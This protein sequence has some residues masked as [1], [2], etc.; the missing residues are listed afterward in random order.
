L[1]QHCVLS[2]KEEKLVAS[3]YTLISSEALHPLKAEREYARLFRNFVIEYA[4]LF[5]KKVEDVGIK[6]TITTE[7]SA[8]SEVRTASRPSPPNP[9]AAPNLRLP[10]LSG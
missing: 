5:A 2:E 6:P 10:S 1:Q 7:P 3:L 9:P 8:S 4:L